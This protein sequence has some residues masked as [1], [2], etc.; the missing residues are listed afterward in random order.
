MIFGTALVA[1]IMTGC[2]N[3]DSIESPKG[4]QM[5]FSTY[6]GKS[7]ITK[8]T[9]VT[10]TTFANGTTVGII[11]YPDFTDPDYS[12]SYPTINNLK[13]TSDATNLKP[14]SDVYWPATGDLSFLAYAPYV[15]GNGLVLNAGTSTAAPSLTYT[16]PTVVED[17]IDVMVSEPQLNQTAATSAGAVALPFHH[18]LTQ[19][20]FSAKTAT[21][22][23]GTAGRTFTVQSIVLKQLNGEGNLTL[24]YAAPLTWTTLGKA[25]DFTIPLAAENQAV[26][27]NGTAITTLNATDGILMM[28]PQ[29]LTND[30]VIEFTYTQ[31]D[32][33]PNTAVTKTFKLNEAIVNGNPLTAWAANKVINYCFTLADNSGTPITFTGSIV[34]WENETNAGL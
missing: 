21:D 28:I 10:G 12:T 5:D 2:V 3:S 14:A 25:T 15:G 23:T 7:T 34:D 11:A 8:G 26:N 17:Q 1:V 16:V 4:A 22:Y 31:S 9:P 20:K 13:L 24:N 33:T 18:A 6:I 19:V 29:T 32:G 30:M 27:T